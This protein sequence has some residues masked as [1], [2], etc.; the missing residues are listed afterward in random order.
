MTAPK[1]A[2]A[3]QTALPGDDLAAQILAGLAAQILALDDRRKRVDGPI[4]ETFRSPPQ[5]S[6]RDHRVRPA[7]CVERRARCQ[8]L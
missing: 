1:A 8:G 4:V 6:P 5:A 2:E 7:G 3:R